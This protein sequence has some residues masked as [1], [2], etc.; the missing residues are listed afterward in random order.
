MSRG[1]FGATVGIDRLLEM[2]EKYNIKAT[3]F[4]PGHTAESFPVRVRKI[5]DKGHELGL[6]GYSHELLPDLT[7]QQQHDVMV[8]SID[9]I[10]KITGKSPKGYTAPGWQV[11]KELLPMLKQYGLEYDHSLMHHDTQPYWAPFEISGVYTNFKVHK[12][13]SEWMH[14]MSKM[15]KTPSKIVE[16]PSNWH[17]DDWPALHFSFSGGMSPNGFVDP[18]VLERLWCD[19]FDYAYRQYDSFIFPMSIHPQVSGEPQ[20]ILMHERIIEHINKHEGVEWMTFGQMAD[21]FKSGAIKGHVVD[22]DA[23]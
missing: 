22:V 20:N 16:I 12:D 14:P 5:H 23:Y 17:L 13:A 2:Y 10:K 9:V 6:H 21:E 8:K 1:I 18:Y 7:V 3:W 15:N 19:Q 4:V 11:S